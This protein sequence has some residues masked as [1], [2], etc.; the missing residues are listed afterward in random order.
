MPIDSRRISSESSSLPPVNEADSSMLLTPVDKISVFSFSLPDPCS[1]NL[2]NPG[3]RSTLCRNH[4]VSMPAALNFLKMKPGVETAEN[5]K[6]K[7]RYN[8]LD[9]LLH[10]QKKSPRYE[11]DTTVIPYSIKV[12]S[13]KGCEG[14][15]SSNE[16]R[17]HSMAGFRGA[18]AKRYKARR[19][20]RS[21]Y[22]QWIVLH[23]IK[24][25]RDIKKNS[26][27]KHVLGKNRHNYFI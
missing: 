11:S 17:R 1:V 12:K 4:A 23:S 26:R 27:E 5:V 21:P 14:R 25:I 2:F 16:F 22:W 9:S 6:I 10:K 3:H 19:Y 24:L 13:S 15:L 7:A 18:T 8:T 20:A